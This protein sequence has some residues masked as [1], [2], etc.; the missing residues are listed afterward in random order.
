MLLN[1]ANACFNDPRTQ[2]FSS[3][4]AWLPIPPAPGHL[5]NPVQQQKAREAAGLVLELMEHVHN[6]A[7]DVDRGVLPPTA[8][9]LTEAEAHADSLA[10][11]RGDI[12]AMAT[13]EV[14]AVSRDKV[15]TRIREE[16]EQIGT[17][18]E[19]TVTPATSD[20]IVS[21]PGSNVRASITR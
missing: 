4:I 15:I 17:L 20:Y 11:I 10:I 3:G 5:V 8:R 21:P 1:Y 19:V 9:L 18:M 14:P 7:A 6:L 13:R 16:M 12:S 2:G